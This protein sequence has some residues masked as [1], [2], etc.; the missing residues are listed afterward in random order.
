MRILAVGHTHD[1]GAMNLELLRSGHEVRVHIEDPDSRDVLSGLV[2]RTGAWQDE[3]AWVREPSADGPSGLIVFEGMGWGATQDRLRG[4]GYAVIGGSAY[5][6][7]LEIDRFYGQAAMAEAGLSIAPSR[8]LMGFDAAIDFVRSHPGRYVLKFEGSG[9]ASTRSYVGVLS[10]GRDML[11]ALTLQKARWT[12]DEVPRIVLM[13]HLSGVEVGV[14]A[15]F[16]GQRFLSP[17]NIDFEHKRFFPGNLGEL[18]GEMGT[19]VAY[20]GAERLFA[21]TL[22]RFESRFRDAGHVGY[23]NLNLIVNDEGAWPLEFTCRFGV[24]GFAILRALHVEGWDALLARLVRPHQALPAVGARNAGEPT[25]EPAFPT[26]DGFAVGIVL[27][28]PPFP[29]PD[30]YERLSKGVPVILENRDAE[31]VDHMHLGE[32][33][34]EHGTLITAGQI[35]YVMVVTGRGDSVANARAAA[36]RR[37]SKVIVPNLRYRN[38]IGTGFETRDFAELVRLGWLTNADRDVECG[39]PDLRSRAVTSS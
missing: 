6:D 32:V 30:G 2:P 16:D 14:G 26:Y 12:Y 33:A 38:D 39:R 3:L 9:F 27:T 25:L 19:L 35:G 8:E 37:A 18:T 5:G 28:V 21:A 34:L 29:Y 20:R 7:R 10:D 13:D 24:P 4:E 36:L 1:L 31:D 23:V 17:A 11:S 22:G 15:F